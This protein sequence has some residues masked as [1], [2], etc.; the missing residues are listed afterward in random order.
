MNIGGQGLDGAIEPSI[1]NQ[2]H[3]TPAD[4]QQPTVS[5]SQPK[6]KPLPSYLTPPS[7]RKSP[8]SA[9]TSDSSTREWALI[10]VSS[11][12]KPERSLRHITKST[13]SI[14]LQKCSFR[15]LLVFC[16]KLLSLGKSPI[17]LCGDRGADQK[18]CATLWYLVVDCWMGFA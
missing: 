14:H 10:S 4:N 12:L 13:E 7:L 16:R 5:S 18:W 3:M 11:L 15:K 9:Q 17:D 2:S 8:P 1:S 6:R